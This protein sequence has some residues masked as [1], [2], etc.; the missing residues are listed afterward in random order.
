[1]CGI[2]GGKRHFRPLS[3]RAIFGVSFFVEPY[4]KGVRVASPR[5]ASRSDT[6]TVRPSDSA[7]AVTRA[8][9]AI[10]DERLGRRAIYSGTEIMNAR[11]APPL[12]ARPIRRL[13]FVSHATPQDSVFAK[14]LATQL[15]IAGY[16]VWCDVTKLLGGEKFW[17]DIA[18]PIPVKGLHHCNARI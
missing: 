13:L 16:E 15:A 10:L 8:S 6:I 9:Q 7:F 1:V 12:V 18:V 14:W 4:G 5:S 3:P 2:C 17:S 11:S